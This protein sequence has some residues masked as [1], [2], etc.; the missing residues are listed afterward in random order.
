MYVHTK[1]TRKLYISAMALLLMFGTVAAPSEVVG[2]QIAQAKTAK[3]AKTKAAKPK[4]SMKDKTSGLGFIRDFNEKVKKVYYEDKANSAI[5]KPGKD[6]DG[7]LTY[8][9]F[10]KKGKNGKKTYKIKAKYFGGGKGHWYK[11]KTYADGIH[12]V[13]Y[14]GNGGKSA[15][16]GAGKTGVIYPNV[17]TYHNMHP[18]KHGVPRLDKKKVSIKITWL[19][20]PKKFSQNAQ[21]LNFHTGAVAVSAQGRHSADRFKIGYYTDTAG[22]KPLEIDPK[23]GKPSTAKSARHPKTQLTFKDI[24]FNQYIGLRGAKSKT[25]K[26]FNKAYYDN[27]KP[28]KRQTT[29][30]RPWNRDAYK[31]DNTLWTGGAMASNDK[32]ENDKISDSASGTISSNDPRGWIGFIDS[33]SKLYN[34][35][36]GD[37]N[38]SYIDG[39]SDSAT[40]ATH[41][42]SSLSKLPVNKDGVGKNGL[43]A[44]Y[45]NYFK[46]GTPKQQ[47]IRWKP[48]ASK[49]VSDKGIVN[50][51]HEGDWKSSMIVDD[52][53]KPIYYG[54][55]SS[56]A[57]P[58]TYHGKDDKIYGVQGFNLVDNQIN[59]GLDI[60]K[61]GTKVYSQTSIGGKYT[62]CSDMFTIT[63]DN[64]RHLAA[65]V[66]KDKEQNNSKFFGHRYCFV[67]ETKPNDK[68]ALNELSKDADG[69][70]TLGTT[71]ENVALF[72]TNIP[73]RS[74]PPEGTPPDGTPPADTPRDKTT[75]G[76]TS[77]GRVHIKHKHPQVTVK[78]EEGKGH[79]YVFRKTAGNS[80]SWAD[81]L[82]QNYDGGTVYP[83]QEL[84]YRIILHLPNN[85][86]DGD[87]ES[88]ITSAHIVDKPGDGITLTS[89]SETSKS[90][91]NGSLVSF[92]VTAKVDKDAEI[93]KDVTNSAEATYTVRTTTLDPVANGKVDKN[94]NPEYDY[95]P[96]SSDRNHSISINTTK[97]KVIK[98]SV[99]PPIKTAYAVENGK[100]IP[101][102]RL[103]YD[104]QF[105]FVIEQKVGTKN[106]DFAGDNFVMSDTLPDNFKA[107]GLSVKVYRLSNSANADPGDKKIGAAKSVAIDD[108]DTKYGVDVTDSE[109]HLEQSDNKFTWTGDTSKMPLKGETYTMVITGRYQ[110]GGEKSPDDDSD[111][112]LNNTAKDT[113]GGTPTES[114]TISI[115]VERVQ[116][117]LSK[118][119]V[120]IHNDTTNQDVNDFTDVLKPQDNYTI[121]YRFTTFAG[122][123]FGKKNNYTLTDPLPENMKVVSI[124]TPKGYLVKDD[125]PDGISENSDVVKGVKTSGTGTDTFK[126]TNDNVTPYGQ[127]QIDVKASVKG[128]GDWSDYYSQ[129]IYNNGGPEDSSKNKATKPSY[130]KI[131]NEAKEVYSDSNSLDAKNSASIAFN[132][133]VQMLKVKEYIA[134]DDNKWSTDLTASHY[135]PVGDKYADNSKKAVTTLLVI[136]APNYVKDQK[137]H[138]SDQADNIANKNPMAKESGGFD[139]GSSDLSLIDNDKAIAYKNDASKLDF[140]NRDLSPATVKANE[141]NSKSVT[142]KELATPGQT[143]AYEQKFSPKTKY[144]AN[145]ALLKK[146]H[147]TFSSSLAFE[148]STENFKG[149][150]VDPDTGSKDINKVGIKLPNIYGFT[151]RMSKGA[152][153]QDG[154]TLDLR[155]YGEQVGLAVDND[156]KTKFTDGTTQFN[157]PDSAADS[158]KVLDVNKPLASDSNY[159]N[160]SAMKRIGGYDETAENQPVEMFIS[161][162]SSSEL[163]KSKDNS[164]DNGYLQ[165]LK[166]QSGVGQGEKVKIG[167][168]TAKDNTDFGKI[169]ATEF[170][171]SKHQNDVVAAGSL[172]GF[173]SGSARTMTKGH[174]V[175]VPVTDPDDKTENDTLTANRMTN[176]TFEPY[177]Q[178]VLSDKTSDNQDL[179]KKS[180]DV[181]SD[182]TAPNTIVTNPSQFINYFDFAA[183]AKAAKPV[184][185]NTTQRVL[186]EAYWLT[187]PKTMSAKA[188]YGL[189]M[190]YVLHSFTLGDIPKD[191]TLQ[192]LYQ[193]NLQ[194]KDAIFD[195]GNTKTANDERLGFSYDATQDVTKITTALSDSSITNKTTL[196]DLLD[197]IDPSKNKLVAAD[198]DW[199]NILPVYNLTNIN[200]RFNNRILDHGKQAFADTDVMYSD[201]NKNLLGYKPSSDLVKGGFRNYLRDDLS[202]AKYPL[203][204]Y[205]STG[206]RG[207]IDIAGFGVGY[208]TSFDFT[209]DLDIYGTRVASKS[210][211]DAKNSDILVEPAIS[212]NN[213]TDH[214]NLKK[215][216]NDWLK[217]ND[218]NSLFDNSTRSKIIER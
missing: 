12:F 41:D 207:L 215:D 113:V 126:M 209:Q 186:R 24:D 1:K 146:M 20:G 211:H 149:N 86:N 193:T 100:L 79:K 172:I 184:A 30:V 203:N 168:D 123:E 61:E 110:S 165:T 135:L 187:A 81:T 47:V 116:P 73:V 89:S 205:S 129:M 45:G 55:F 157:L 42:P 68:L 218:A 201:Y 141:T 53:S 94:G 6:I 60:I 151:M 101:L 158:S 37:A 112:V 176:T 148:D 162:R 216:G 213:A 145:Y 23:T 150:Y 159:T 115:P 57:W 48:S 50:G 25:K 125:T 83:G 140:T 17:A 35:G 144:A 189:E 106:V 171:P 143:Y 173:T 32:K 197:A 119:I 132:M 62:D 139:R 198:D 208:A 190:P 7:Y 33:D 58:A 52:L 3:K 2:L 212:G 5:V 31:K 136:E 166:L 9:S 84:K 26:S 128:Q 39:T 69:K 15:N 138:I 72:N 109:G 102:S 202:I 131:P 66:L 96:H 188:G 34:Y 204:L 64:K 206:N 16:S 82:G 196:Q 67:I 200:F 97:N 95:V 147:S 22:K 142:T 164:H 44:S 29:K 99:T 195:G 167:T 155:T 85:V 108:D 121:T 93:G 71:L 130:M 199:L 192:G 27:G 70:E 154:K 51:K 114:N 14:S 160:D 161:P 122:N 175:V 77:V 78:P 46:L 163:A 19:G 40:P 80:D 65:A 105:K 111:Y 88:H 18:D 180:K 63:V 120:A 179:Q 11:G 87:G 91:S 59:P 10:T 8:H 124:G 4:V 170:W 98:P 177:K 127:I 137:V 194:S 178:H 36:H 104:K 28:K 214:A 181:K 217:H 185:D 74:I 133:G 75:G 182:F 117:S 134:Q 118:D 56:A 92:D 156:N 76:K 54:I 49:L 210:D 169:D 153:G 103:E 43:L 38:D 174:S 183:P 191:D 21:Q 152:Y 13:K 90:A 107:A